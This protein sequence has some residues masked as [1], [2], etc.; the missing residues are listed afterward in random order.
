M[1]NV[2]NLNLEIIRQWIQ[3]HKPIE[4][5]QEAI[6]CDSVNPPGNVM[7]FVKII[8]RTLYYYGIETEIYRSN[9]EKANIVA[10]VKGK[11][12]G[13]RL[14]FSG[15]LDTVPIGEKTWDHSPFSGHIENGKIYGRGSSDMKSGL[16]AFIYA[17]IF[18]KSTQALSTGELVFIATFDEETGSLGAQQM[19]KEEQI[20]EFDAMIIGEPTDNEIVTSH[21]GALWVK[22]DSF[23]K[24]AHGSMPESGVNAINGMKSFIDDISG[25]SL[26]KDNIDQDILT[27]STMAVTMIEGGSNYNVIPDYCTSTIDFR[28]TPDKKNS[29][30]LN[31]L[32]TYISNTSKKEDTP[33]ISIKPIVNLAPL[34]TLD[35]TEIVKVT[36]DTFFEI[37][38]INKITKRMNYFTDGSVFSSI[39]R[40]IIILGPGEPSQAHQPNEYV[41]I[42]KFN[43]SIE[44]YISIAKNY[45]KSS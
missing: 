2:E 10:K 28:T 24:T 17:M 8:Q 15:H 38:N 19:I 40:N 7:D 27:K 34:N 21:K 4:L 5:L 14:I 16:V 26:F 44:L 3:K 42:K 45:L 29:D 39:S 36:K 37:Y 18:L 6:Q 12:K 11:H 20:N 33:H 23:G 32:H 13:K 25:I 43:Q 35:N 22:V 30:I 1:I 41:N 9:L 31:A